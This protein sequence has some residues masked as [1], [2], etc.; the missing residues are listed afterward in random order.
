MNTELMDF[1]LK[2]RV[3]I[4]QIVGMALLAPKIQEDILLSGDKA[5]FQV[6][7]YKINDLVREADWDKQTKSWQALLL[8]YSEPKP[9][10]ELPS[11]LLA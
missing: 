2:I 7:E 4:N 8:E 10:A 5:I 1:F 6:P 3:R 11:P 9:K